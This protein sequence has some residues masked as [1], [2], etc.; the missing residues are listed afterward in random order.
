MSTIKIQQIVC[1]CTVRG[2]SEEGGVFVAW[3]EI[4]MLD[5]EEG[6]GGRE[7]SLHGFHGATLRSRTGYTSPGGMIE[8]S[9]KR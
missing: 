2:S 1:Q 8:K 9:T 4:A 7:D 5:T 3:R 6:G